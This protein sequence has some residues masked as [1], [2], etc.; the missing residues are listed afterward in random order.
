MNIL[1]VQTPLRDQGFNPGELDGVWGRRT[2]TAV[3]AFQ[4]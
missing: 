4:T 2:I 3:K 1:D